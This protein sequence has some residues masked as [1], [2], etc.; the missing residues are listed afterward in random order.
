MGKNNFKIISASAGS[1]KTY[2]LVHEYLKILLEDPSDNTFRHSLALTFTNKSVNSMK[3]RILETLFLLSIESNDAKSYSDDFCK[4]FD[5]SK[6]ELASRSMLILKK[7]F[8]EYGSFSVITLDKFTHRLVRTFYR[9]F[10]LPFGFEVSLDS[11][12]LIEE[13]IDSIIDEI[14]I[15]GLISKYLLDF[16]LQKINNDK[17]WDVEIDLKEFI[18]ILFNEN[19]RIPVNYIKK[20]NTKKL[21]SDRVLLSN[22]LKNEKLKVLKNSR[23]ALNFLESLDLRANDFT[24]NRVHKYFEN[25]SKGSFTTKYF[26]QLESSLSGEKPI[27]NSSLTEEKKVLIDNN[28]D[29]IEYY[30]FCVK[31]SV[32]QILLIQRTLASWTPRFLLQLMEDRL[33]KIQNEKKIRI[34]S[35]FNKKINLLVKNEP[36]PFIYERLGS[37]YQHYF[38]DEFQDTSTLQWNNLIPLI[39]N[40]VEGESLS[41]KKGSLFLVG[42]P[43]QSIY[44]WRGGD[45][46]QFIDLVNNIKNP[47]QISASQD[48]L[49]IN[50]RSL[51]E[52]VNFN[53]GLF[54]IISNSFENKYYRKL[55]GESSRQKYIYEGGYV[56]VQAISN[57]GTKG[58][59]TLQYISKTVDITKK[60]IRDGYDQTDIAILVRKKEQAK[61]I[62]IE[63]IKEGFNI[64]S[65]E[66]M[67]VNHSNKVQLIIAI[68]YLSSNPN[69]SRHHKTV[70]DILYELSDSNINDYHH[71][72]VNN[73][74][75][76]TSIF[77]SHLENKFGL[78]FDLEKI[79]SKTIADA[80]DHVLIR[81]SIF[82]M[83]DIYISSFLEDVLEYS[84]L[85]AASID[86]YLNHW[87]SIS[88]KLRI[89]TSESNESIKL[90]T[91]HKAKGLE[92]PIVILPFM[93]SLIYPN[94]IEKIWF[95]FKDKNL[96]NVGWGWFNFSNEIE[97]YGEEGNELHKSYRLNQKL[98]AFNVLYVA[99]TR[100]VEAMFIITKEVDEGENTYAHLLKKYI[101]S[102]VDS[103]NSKTPFIRGKLL[104][105]ANKNRNF[106]GKSGEKNNYS[107][108]L[109]L[110][111]KQHFVLD[112]IKNKN[113]NSSQ[114]K[115]ILIH[116]LLAQIITSDMVAGVV[117]NAIDDKIISIKTKSII[118][119][120]LRKVVT[121]TQLKSLYNGEDKVLCEEDLLVPNGP[122]L[123]PDRINIKK[124]GGVCIIDYK[125]GTPKK[126]D[127]S[128]I[129]SYST[130]L[131]NM[132]YF[133]IENILV[134]IGDKVQVLK[135]KKTKF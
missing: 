119:K 48:I 84:K 43:K 33:E 111:W 28:K 51:K 107:L 36:A 38:L 106:I 20:R 9:E 41:G 134:Y 79:K 31:K 110:N 50:Y 127:E 32:T 131:N 53:K 29:K 44:R 6:Q 126:T 37:R 54:Q 83:D 98:D 100:A 47:F 118:E 58:I 56:N 124:S 112:S 129:L 27:Y 75:V 82:D 46:N 67:L 21:K 87:E 10:N 14:G 120:S 77:F 108:P 62:G 122:T 88:S 65:S 63:L 18:P 72:A 94:V 45:M 90:M 115:G 89:A 11:E 60:L 101:L 91:I 12:S 74:N 52:I 19:D 97:T 99:L 42:D 25:I 114:V 23:E 81:L 55:Y 5:I 102:E 86:S 128:Q 93:D 35:D 70:F 26:K 57:V 49:K 103:F 24:Q 34:N 135:I 8:L 104:I 3:S 2:N 92:F 105:R 7:I 1:G 125:T 22:Y 95:P 130:V 61:E 78:K 30:F 80:V 76:K 68:L 59:T 133:D 15:D 116:N 69:S 17:D 13:T 132:G 123:R 71:F 96:K 73:L 85:S 113:F 66:S 4:F 109:N 39:S 117:Q 16:S 121:H 40:S 64:S